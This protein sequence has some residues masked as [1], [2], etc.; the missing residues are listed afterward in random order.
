MGGRTSVVGR[1]I[2]PARQ[3]TSR[4]PGR[5]QGR[6]GGSCSTPPGWDRIRSAL[7]VFHGF[8]LLAGHARGWSVWSRPER[9]ASL[10]DIL[11]QKGDA[12]R[13]EQ[14][15]RSAQGDSNQ[16]AWAVTTGGGRRGIDDR[17]GDK[18]G[19]VRIARI[20]WRVHL[21]VGGDCLCEIARLGGIPVGDTDFEQIRTRGNVGRHRFGEGQGVRIRVGRV[22]RPV[23]DRGGGGKLSK[24]GDQ[25]LGDL[26]VARV[27]AAGRRVVRSNEQGHV[28]RVRRRRDRGNTDGD[29]QANQRSTQDEPAPGAHDRPEPPGGRRSGGNGLAAH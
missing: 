14:G 8:G 1:G 15:D 18:L 24:C 2:R 7:R 28:G 4:W 26:E 13:Q 27:H 19:H 22:D 3:T 6:L 12:D 5:R 16:K 11:A 9:S 29:D 10:P 20:W 25:R 21:K 17:K 23:E